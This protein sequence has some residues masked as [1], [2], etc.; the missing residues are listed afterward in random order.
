M[1]PVKIVLFVLAGFGVL[2]VTQHLCCF[3]KHHYG[4]NMHTPVDELL[5]W[6]RPDSV[7]QQ[8]ERERKLDANGTTFSP[9]EASVKFEGAQQFN[10][11]EV[12]EE[13]I[14]EQEQPSV[15]QSMRRR[16]QES[17]ESE[18]V[19]REANPK[20]EEMDEAALSRLRGVITSL[21]SGRRRRRQ[22]ISG[23][24]TLS[25]RL[26]SLS[27][28]DAVEV[29]KK[30]QTMP[31]PI[32]GDENEQ[33]DNGAWTVETALPPSPSYLEDPWDASRRRKPQVTTASDNSTQSVS[34]ENAAAE[35]DF[36]V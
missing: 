26:P 14:E 33:E 17:S 20:D 1:K 28:P 13:K 32:D 21:G 7:F 11:T 19:S 9:G 36:A 5:T 24:P 25:R 10:Q 4:L 8:P 31:S 6:V 16:L 34:E 12:K 18:V 23:M 22:F 35:K 15:E 30:K 29:K 3:L 2:V 27:N